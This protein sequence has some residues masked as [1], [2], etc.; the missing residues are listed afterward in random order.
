MYILLRLLFCVEPLVTSY[1]GLTLRGCV[2]RTV[3]GHTRGA[4]RLESHLPHLVSLSGVGLGVELYT[5]KRGVTSV[6]TA[7][8]EQP[9]DIVLPAGVGAEPDICLLEHTVR[10][11]GEDGECACPCSV[12][13]LVVLG[14]CVC[15]CVVSL[16]CV[17]NM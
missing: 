12:G 13:S 1:P 4:L 17:F 15:M 16:G 10:V 7:A 2:H 9:N 8:A 5:L 6:G 3:T 14:L 11:A